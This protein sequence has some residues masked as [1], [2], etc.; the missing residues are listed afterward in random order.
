MC[1]QVPVVYA[2][3]ELGSPMCLYG[4][5]IVSGDD[6]NGDGMSCSNNDLLLEAEEM[7]CM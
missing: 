6:G 2:F 4:D 7:V 5:G 3:K 1:S